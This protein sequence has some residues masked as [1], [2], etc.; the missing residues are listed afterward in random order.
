M[1]DPDEVTLGSGYPA[2]AG[3]AVDA[4]GMLEAAADLVNPAAAARELPWL[5]GELLK[6]AVGR[7]DLTFAEKDPRFRD[8]TWRDNPLFRRL[9]QGYR[10]YEEGTDRMVEAGDG[11]W[12]RQARTRH[13]ANILTRAP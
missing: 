12:E 1:E 4:R 7:S 5:A 10:L 2:A 9:G 8:V 3:Q 13:P 6:I 11:S